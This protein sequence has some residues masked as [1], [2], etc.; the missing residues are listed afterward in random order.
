M[1]NIKAVTEHLTSYYKKN[2]ST[3]ETLSLINTSDNRLYYIDTEG[4]A[5]RTFKYIEDSQTC[6]KSSDPELV[7]EA[8]ALLARFEKALLDFPAASLK[9]TIPK[10]LHAPTRFAQFMG[11]S[12][13]C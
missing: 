12:G 13:E 5:W 7:L 10:F 3:D 6:W 4:N 1:K 9:E 11:I 2:S 8:A